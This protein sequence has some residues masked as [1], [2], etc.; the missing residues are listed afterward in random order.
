MCGVTLENAR[1]R[2]NCER[3]QQQSPDGPVS[4]K[5]NLILTAMIW[6]PE[7]TIIST[8]VTPAATHGVVNVRARALQAIDTCQPKGNSSILYGSVSWNQGEPFSPRQ[9][10]LDNHL[11]SLL[12]GDRFQGCMEGRQGLY[13]RRKR[14]RLSLL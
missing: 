13:H 14:T 7:F 2:S 9:M 8:V 1:D 3:E 12:S 6:C 4:C 11:V 10:K 5:V